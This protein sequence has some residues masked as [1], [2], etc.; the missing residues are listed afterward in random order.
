MSKTAQT[1]EPVIVPV[2]EF[3]IGGRGKRRGFIHEGCN[4]WI[5]NGKSF[6][7]PLVFAPADDLENELCVIC[8]KPILNTEA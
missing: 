2:S 4:S 6:S 1:I 5:K 7:L 3:R 8:E